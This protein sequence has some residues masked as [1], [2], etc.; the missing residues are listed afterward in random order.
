MNTDV[1]SEFEILL[2]FA[3]I[4]SPTGS[5]VAI[6][7]ASLGELY[8]I[9]SHQLS[10]FVIFVSLLP[11][12]GKRIAQEKQLF[13]MVGARPRRFPRIDVSEVVQV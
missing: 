7:I 3:V 13:A 12:G 5:F 4:R 11:V 2:G 1:F 9:A 10:Q 8:P 6:G